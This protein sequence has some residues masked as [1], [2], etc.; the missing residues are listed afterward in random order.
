MEEVIM[1]RPRAGSHFSVSQLEELLAARLSQIAVL[2]GQKSDLQKQIDAIDR[3]IRSLGGHVRGKRGRGPG[4]PAGKVVRVG[5]RRR[6]A[7]NAKSLTEV[8][9]EVLTGSGA[10]SVSDI[11]AAAQAAGY[12]SKS[13]QFRNIV[14]QAL[15]KDKRFGSSERGMYFLKK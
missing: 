1:P 14:N 5:R 7:K 11:A 4:R 2:E 3:E 13:S 6:R 15:I 10:K 12:K 9:V 8:I